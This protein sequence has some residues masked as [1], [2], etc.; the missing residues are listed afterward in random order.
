[1]AKALDV[2]KY[3]IYLNQEDN[4][5]DMP[6]LKLQQL[7]YYSHGV[8]QLEINMQL[9]NEPIL[10]WRLGASVREVFN[11]YKIHG[12]SNIIED[13][14]LSKL[15]LTDSEIATIKEVW[16]AFKDVPASVLVAMVHSETPWREAWEKSL[17]EISKNHI[18][19]YFKRNYTN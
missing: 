14:D 6:N 1:M 5:K 15:K 19:E 18:M 11:I 9:F 3:L 7:L 8:H 13:I 2:A 17:S 4:I 16:D 12:Y 10:A